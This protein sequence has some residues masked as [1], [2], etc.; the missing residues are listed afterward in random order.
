MDGLVQPGDAH[1]HGEMVLTAGESLEQA[2]AALLMLHGRGATAPDILS[3]ASALT[4]PGF[5]FLAPQAAGDSWYPNSFL[6]PITG[7]E[8]QL[9]EA[10]ALIERLL[11]Q[12]AAAGIPPARTI[13]LG[14]SQGACLALEYAA[15]HARR[16]GGV[17]GW[18]G[19]LIGPDGMP[20]DYTGSLAG[21]PIF[22]GCSDRDPYIALARVDMT[23]EVLQRLDGDVT[24][25][26]YPGMDHTVNQD[27]VDAVRAMM[28]A[29]AA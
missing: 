21:T 16:Y 22:L 12:M 26:I 25:R 4:R 5:A 24:E 11:A 2:Y 19:G 27:E 9:S 28:A 13:L 10:F 6:D 8:P 20:R 7:N 17:V 23:A 29:L 18:S 3:F 15:L 1:R 14:F